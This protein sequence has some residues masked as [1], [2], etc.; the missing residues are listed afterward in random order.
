MD[1]LGSAFLLKP[2]VFFANNLVVTGG[3]PSCFTSG[4]AEAKPV[5]KIKIATAILLNF[6]IVVVIT[7]DVA[8]ILYRY[9]IVLG[10]LHVT[11]DTSTYRLLYR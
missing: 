7:V 5:V 4:K 2:F 8:T 11:V 9:R 1:F 6:A 10:L 3:L